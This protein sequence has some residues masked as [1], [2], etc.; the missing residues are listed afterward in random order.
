MSSKLR[1]SCDL[2]ALTK[3]GCTKEKPVCARCAKR[4]QSCIY[5]AAKRVGRTSGGHGSH[6]PKEDS[7]ARI[8]TTPISPTLAAAQTLGCTAASPST[9]LGAALFFP[10]SPDLSRPQSPPSYPSIFQTLI[11]PT[12]DTSLSP[13][14]SNS[15][16]EWDELFASAPT[17]PLENPLDGD[18]S[19]ASLFDFPG[20]EDFSEQSSST[21]HSSSSNFTNISSRTSGSCLFPGSSEPKANGAPA[22]TAPVPSNRSPV[23]AR[24]HNRGD[25]HI[26][27][28]TTNGSQAGKQPFPPDS[29]P[30]QC[31][32]RV[33]GLL[34]RLCPG[35]SGWW[36]TLGNPNENPSSCEQLPDFEHIVAQNEQTS[37]VIRII[38][39]CSCSNDSYLLVTLSLVVFKIIA[40]Y[41]AA[42]RAASGEEPI[43]GRGASGGNGNSSAQCSQN[44]HHYQYQNHAFE[45]QRSLLPT[46][47][48]PS[49]SS[50]SS[51]SSPP[52]T[53]NNN[54]RNSEHDSEGEDQ[55][56]IAVQ[57]ILSK[58][59][60][61][62]VSVDELSDRLRRMWDDQPSKK[63]KNG[64]NNK[65]MMDPSPPLLANSAANAASTSGSTAGYSLAVGENAFT[66]PFSPEFAYTLEADLRKRLYELSQAIVE[67]LRGG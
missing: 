38:L 45:T 50:S 6:A 11:S 8:T 31:L 63:N 30:C 4:E 40:W 23:V 25:A 54:L 44:S 17:L 49:S 37:E 14:P 41:T 56:R 46:P 32:G 48:S 34:A 3:V 10:S 22:P 19:G 5:S 59:A 1:K 27:A 16:T 42:A 15:F 55:Q 67:R 66:R 35:T 18:P 29:S 28:T 39:Q 36:N 58:L 47:S 9:P 65:M 33:L 2:C 60:G 20:L 43:P 64:D 52:S 7:I 26:P 57:R 12:G 51:S 13:V 61:V 53:N 24:P 62:H 21:D